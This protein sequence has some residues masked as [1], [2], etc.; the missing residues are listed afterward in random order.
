MRG[1]LLYH[2]QLTTTESAIHPEAAIQ[3]S[4]EVAQTTSAKRNTHNTSNVHKLR[5][6]HSSQKRKTSEMKQ[7]PHVPCNWRDHQMAHMIERSL[8]AHGFE[9]LQQLHQY[10]DGST[11]EKGSLGRMSVRVK[12]VLS[13]VQ[14]HEEV[15]CSGHDHCQRNAFPCRNNSTLTV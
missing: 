3:P 6:D 5:C 13:A 15:M 1:G 10:S 2:T 9:M 8:R 14:E 11:R 4:Q 7:P 12:T